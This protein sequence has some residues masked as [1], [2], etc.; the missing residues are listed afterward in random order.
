MGAYVFGQR[1]LSKTILQPTGQWDDFLPEYE[2]QFGDGWD[3]YS[4]TVWGTLNAIEI[5]DR[6]LFD[7]CS[8][9]SERFICNIVPVRPPGSDPYLIAEA[10][11][12]NGLIEQDL[13]PMTTSFEGFIIPTP[14]SDDFLS[15]GKEW[16]NDYEFCHEEVWSGNPAREA[17]EDLLIECLQYSPIGVSV[18]AW[19]LEKGVYVDYGEP[20]NHWCVLIGYQLSAGKILWKVFDSYDQTVKVLSEEHHIERAKRYLLKKKEVVELPNIF[21]LWIS[22]IVKWFTKK[23]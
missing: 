17:K 20:N 12:K 13:L 9:Y 14:V 1:K 3:T 22:S 19:N 6:R 5:L 7:K 8:N 23:V 15:K 18:T 21:K 10:I 2:P 11:R 4:C 16:L